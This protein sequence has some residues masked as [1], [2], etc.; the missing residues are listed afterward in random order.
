M[1]SRVL[2][3]LIA[4]VLAVVATVAMVVYVKAA[5]DRALAGQQP[6]RVLV[7]EKLIPHGMSGEDAQ[8]G[9]YIKEIVVPLKSALKGRVLSRE[10]LRNR[11]AAVNIVPGEQLLLERWVGAQDLGGK[12]LLPIPEGHQAVSIGV[13]LVRQVAGFVTP[14]DKVGLVVTMPSGDEGGDKTITVLP[15]VQVL[16]VGATALTRSS[17]TANGGRVN[18]GKGSQTLTA[19]TLAVEN[20]DVRKVIFAAEEG[21]LYLTLLSPTADRAPAT[22]E[23]GAVDAGDIFTRP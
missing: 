15:E 23:G 2:A 13:D 22:P 21:S 11:Y 1:Q 12:D 3:I 10:Q 8:N 16:A 19:V 17:T 20:K 7:A 14:G 6:T 4:V 18:Q 9:P 5:D